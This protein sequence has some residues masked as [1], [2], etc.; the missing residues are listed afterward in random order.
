MPA[1]VLF[2]SSDQGNLVDYVKSRLMKIDGDIFCMLSNLSA[3]PDDVYQCQQI[4][5]DF[6]NSLN[7]YKNCSAYLKTATHKTF[8]CSHIEQA[9]QGQAPEN[10][11]TYSVKTDM[12]NSRHVYFGCLESIIIYFSGVSGEAAYNQWRGY[13]NPMGKAMDDIEHLI[14]QIAYLMPEDPNRKPSNHSQKIARKAQTD[15]NDIEKRAAEQEWDSG[16]YKSVR[17]CARD[18]AKRTQLEEETL[19][20]HLLKYRRQKT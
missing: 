16:N 20:R 12:T 7:T 17:A 5:Q 2:A 19:Y 6:M 1:P 13:A 9:L 14:E 10:L 4:Y 18:F 3:I 15:G 11:H 8:A